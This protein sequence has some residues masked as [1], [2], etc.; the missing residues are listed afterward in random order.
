MTDGLKAQKHIAWGNALCTR[1]LVYSPCKVGCSKSTFKTRPFFMR[2]QYFKTL[3]YNIKAV[4]EVVFFGR[5][6]ICIQDKIV[7]IWFQCPETYEYNTN[8]IFA[9][10][11]W[12]RSNC[13]FWTPY[14]TGRI[15][16]VLTK[17]H[18]AMPWAMCF[19][20]FRSFLSAA[21]L[22]DVQSAYRMVAD[23][24]VCEQM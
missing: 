20:P 9:A 3:I 21:D 2:F 4:F 10:N 18:R 14:H 11:F 17:Y 12:S 24:H 16:P 6:K 13:Q 15:N 8:V 5:V 1:Q 19:W 22:L 23:N 7:F